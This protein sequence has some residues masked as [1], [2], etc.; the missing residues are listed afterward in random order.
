MLVEAFILCLA[1]ATSTKL[2]DF[3]FFDSGQ[4][5][6]YRS[7]QLASDIR[8]DYDLKVPVF[9]VLVETPSL[10]DTA[11]KE[12]AHILGQLNAETL[13]FLEVV[14]S[15]RG[16]AGGGYHTSIETAK[17]LAA[18][19][20]GFRISLLDEQGHILRR[21]T[22]PLSSREIRAVARRVNRRAPN[23]PMKH[24]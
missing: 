8:R 19:H 15:Q 5:R 12:Q 24:S 20:R 11:F 17:R 13:G 23:K 21:S 22:A 14:A 10:D 1:T 2:I 16:D 3:E 18:G 6:T 7:T 9:L 4:E